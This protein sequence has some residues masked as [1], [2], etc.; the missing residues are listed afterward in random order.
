MSAALHTQYSTLH[1][2][3]SVPAAPSPLLSTEDMIWSLD[4]TIN[5]HV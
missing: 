2:R 5:H 4:R 3:L 1:P